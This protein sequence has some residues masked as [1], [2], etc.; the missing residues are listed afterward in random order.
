M[1]ENRTPG[2]V[3]G[4]PGNRCPYCDDGMNKIQ[5]KALATLVIAVTVVMVVSSV[6]YLRYVNAHDEGSVYLAILNPAP[7]LH[8]FKGFVALSRPS[9]C[10]STEANYVG[11]PPNV[12]KAFIRVNAEGAKPIRL[13][14][15]EGEVPIVSWSETERMYRSG[16]TEQFHPQGRILLKLSRVG[17]NEQETE[18]IA[19]IET[20]DGS[21][22][23]SRLYYLRKDNEVWKAISSHMIWVS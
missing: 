7:E 2:S 6:A 9:I 4:A 8:K 14:S 15:L 22:G 5:K 23:D 1:R 19:C 20:S 18:A 17:F 3:Q 16:I 13:A 21:Y 10:N 11:I 12:V